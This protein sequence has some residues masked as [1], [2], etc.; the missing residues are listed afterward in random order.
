MLFGRE[1]YNPFWANKILALGD[2]HSPNVN[3]PTFACIFIRP[4][5]VR[6]RLLKHER[7]ALAHYAHG[8]DR[9]HQRI[10]I[11]FQ[12]IAFSK[13]D[14]QKYQSDFFITLMLMCLC[15]RASFKFAA[16]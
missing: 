15:A 1:I 16:T 2:K 14:H 3:L 9:V 8:I 7:Y 6:K 10:D 12:Q 4:E 5:I 11:G 13:L